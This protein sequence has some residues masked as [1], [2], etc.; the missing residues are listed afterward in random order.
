MNRCKSLIV[1]AAAAGLVL[2]ASCSGDRA[3]TAPDPAKEPPSLASGYSYAWWDFTENSVSQRIALSS[4]RDEGTMLEVWQREIA[5]QGAE[6]RRIE[7]PAEEWDAAWMLFQ[8][9]ERWPP[10]NHN[11]GCG[12]DINCS[13]FFGWFS[14]DYGRGFCVES[15]KR[16]EYEAVRAVMLALRDRY[17]SVD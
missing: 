8:D 3:V 6:M 5:K 12:D 2:I 15:C 9:A 10:K 17:L 4:F 16:K 1:C 13:E 7:I 14:G 11:Y